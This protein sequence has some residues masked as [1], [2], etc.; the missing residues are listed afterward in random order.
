METLNQQAPKQS[1]V[2]PAVC[3]LLKGGVPF[4]GSAD[5]TQRPEGKEPAPFLGSWWGR[6]EE[7]RGRK[8]NGNWWEAV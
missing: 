4:L 2:D 6:G 1:H 8:W 3:V 5:R 7:H